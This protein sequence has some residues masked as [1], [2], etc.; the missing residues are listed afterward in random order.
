MTPTIVR[1][2]NAFM[3]RNWFRIA[4]LISAGALF[5]NLSSCARNQHLV[6]IT[7][8]PATVTFS[9]VD[10][11][12]FVNLTAYGA[13]QHPPETKDITTRVTWKSDTPQV[14]QVTTAGVVSPS[15]NCGTAAVTATFNDSGNL[16]VSNSVT[17]TVDG[18]ASQNCPTHILFVSV[19]GGAN[20]VIVS[21]PSGID[22]GATCSAAFASGSSVALTATPNSGHTFGG[23]AAGCTTVSGTTCNVTMNA[24]VTVSATFN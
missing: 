19:T 8:Q 6:S 24:D 10:D 5:G 21:S 9:A 18:P 2:Q 16:I 1:E 17:I 12:L 22:C 13:Y 7:V 20:G 14:A 4:A 3:T 23:W 11:K 15:T